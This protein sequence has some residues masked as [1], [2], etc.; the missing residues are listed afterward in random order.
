MVPKPSEFLRY[1]EQFGVA[2]PPEWLPVP[3]AEQ[4]ALAAVQVQHEVARQVRNQ[5]RRL[6]LQA[7]QIAAQLG[8]SK[9]Q[10]LRLL[11]GESAMTAVRMH[12]IARAV[13]IRLTML[14]EPQE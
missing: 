12:Q 14:V 2:D 5:M 6:D 9:E 3:A 11:R 7:E 13:A 10:Y 4:A 1:P 8:M